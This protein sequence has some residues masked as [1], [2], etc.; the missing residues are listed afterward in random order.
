[1]NIIVS[2]LVC[3]LVTT[4]V[5]IIVSIN[6]IV[7]VSGFF[8][9]ILVKCGGH[10][11]QVNNKGKNIGTATMNQVMQFLFWQVTVRRM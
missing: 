8:L 2:T 7:T 3:T 5:R 11:T 1:M 4:L 6:L 9:N 10:G